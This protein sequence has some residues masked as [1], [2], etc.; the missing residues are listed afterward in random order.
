MLTHRGCKKRSPGSAGHF[1]SE[2]RGGIT[3]WRK[4]EWFLWAF[5]GS[6]GYSSLEAKKSASAQG[7]APS[8]PNL[9]GLE[10]NRLQVR[11]RL[12]DC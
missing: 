12:A 10:R 5:V 11:G 9:S 2:G 3:V 7:S 6:E 8:E 1:A 4:A